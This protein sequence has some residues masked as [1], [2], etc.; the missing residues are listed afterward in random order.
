MEPTFSRDGKS[1]G[2]VESQVIIKSIRLPARNL[3]Y[4][5]RTCNDMIRRERHQSW[6]WQRWCLLHRNV[7]LM[8]A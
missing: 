8:I 2:G 3:S 4:S 7:D 5:H 6:G 1:V